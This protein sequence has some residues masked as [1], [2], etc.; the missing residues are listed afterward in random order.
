MTLAGA[1][2][3]QVDLRITQRDAALWVGFGPPR[4]IVS[5]RLDRRGWAV[6]SVVHELAH[7][8]G[9]H[10]PRDFYVRSPGWHHKTESQANVLGLLALW[11][12]PGGS[13]PRILTIAPSAEDGMISFVVAYPTHEPFDATGAWTTRRLTLRRYAAG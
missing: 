8:V 12:R 10:G 6:F 1:L 7:Y 3:I 9:H 5:H 13:Y 2:G 4:I 11:P